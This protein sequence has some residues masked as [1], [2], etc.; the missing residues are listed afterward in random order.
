M[1]EL[2]GTATA[3]SGRSGLPALL[4]SFERIPGESR[5]EALSRVADCLPVGLKCGVATDNVVQ[6][7]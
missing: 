3:E 5:A 7:G 6:L 4:L 2:D 1:A